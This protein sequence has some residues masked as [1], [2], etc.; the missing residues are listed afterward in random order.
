MRAFG[1]WGASG[2]VRGRKSRGAQAGFS[3]VYV[4]VRWRCIGMLSPGSGALPQAVMDRASASFARSMASR[5]RGPRF[6][7][8]L[9]TNSEYANHITA[10]YIIVVI[11]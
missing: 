11:V 10:Y 5:T 3:G 7:A 1:R 6:K 8:S 2:A 9:T 4:E